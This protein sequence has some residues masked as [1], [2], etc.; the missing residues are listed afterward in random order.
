MSSSAETP[1]AARPFEFGDLA[2]LA[3]VAGVADIESVVAEA[4]DRGYLQGVEEGRAAALAGAAPAVDALA[5]GLAALEQEQAA[6]LDR[7]E[8]A[9]VE[10]AL[11]LAGKIVG[12]AIDVRPELVLEVVAGALRRTTVRDQLVLQVNPDDYEL[13]RAAADGLA[14]RIGGI[15]R[16]DVVAERRVERGG[17]VVRTEEG[18]IDGQV[19]EQLSRAAEIAAEAL[20]TSDA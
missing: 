3:A 17:C 16:L 4:R 15:R 13:V 5:T 8:Q 1:A 6:F 18:E 14:D 2:P 7:A 20:Q 12:A 11:A 9:A 19:G 10:L